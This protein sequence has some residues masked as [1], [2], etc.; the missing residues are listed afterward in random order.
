MRRV[1]ELLAIALVVTGCGSVASAYVPPSDPTAPPYVPAATIYLAPAGAGATPTALAANVPAATPISTPAM[2]AA[3]LPAVPLTIATLGD[4]LTEGEGD[5]SGAGYPGRLKTLVDS[6]RPGTRIVNLGKSGWSSTDLMNGLNGERSQLTAAIAAEPDVALVWIGSNDLWYLYEF[7]PE[8]MTTEAEQ[9]DRATYETSIDKIL[10]D[11]T[12]HGVAVYI[13][14]LDDQSKRPVVAAPPNPEDPAFPSTTPADLERM[15]VHVSAYNDIIRSKAAQYHATTV[16][17]SETTI[18][19]DPATL[20]S[21]GNHPNA[22]G[23]QAVAS[24]WFAALK[25]SLG[26]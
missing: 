2:Q 20:D 16:D 26:R 3:A 24:T 5:D 23:Y 9:M 8:P 15:S 21:D 17:F 6:V 1:G 19:T 10:S 22:A 18:F 13:A 7:G 14:L 25:P 4:S 12:G 11:L